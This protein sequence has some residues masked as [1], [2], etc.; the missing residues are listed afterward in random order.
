[1]T[2]GKL[3]ELL[4]KYD[5]DEIVRITDPGSL[6]VIFKDGDAEDLFSFGD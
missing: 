2:V 6:I 3:K 4:N 1:M 5:D